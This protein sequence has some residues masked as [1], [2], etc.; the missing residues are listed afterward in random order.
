[1]WL[2]N[3]RRAGAVCDEHARRR[4]CRSW[5]WW[6]T[7]RAFV[8]RWRRERRGW[9]PWY[10]TCDAERRTGRVHESGR[11]V[12]L[13]GRCSPRRALHGLVRTACGALVRTVTGAERQN[14]GDSQPFRGGAPRHEASFAQ[15]AARGEGLPSERLQSRASPVRTIRRASRPH[16]FLPFKDE[17]YRRGRFEERAVL[18]WVSRCCFRCRRCVHRAATLR[19]RL[20]R[21]AQLQNMVPM[22][23]HAA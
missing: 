9:K 5:L 13:F 11:G 8:E 19:R 12:R 15:A 21:D 3:A 23:V 14:T 6:N 1:M 16:A 7:A 18:L 10:W 4:A 20:R 22:V 2:A 17:R